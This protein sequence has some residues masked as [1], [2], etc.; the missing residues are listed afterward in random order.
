MARK[1]KKAIQAKVTWKRQ[2]NTRDSKVN[3]ETGKYGHKAADCWYKQP[4]KLQGKGK[5]TG[6]SKSKVTEISVSDGSKQVDETWTSNTSTPQPKISQVNTIG[7]ANEGLWIFSLEDS[8]KRRYTVNWEDQSDCK[9][10]RTRVD[11]RF[12]MFWTCLPTPWFAPQFPMVS[13]TIVEAVA[14]NNVGL[15]HFGQK[16]VYGHVMTNSGRRISIQIKFDV[17]SVRNPLLS[18]FALKRRGVTIIFN[19]DDNRF[20]SRNETVIFDNSRLSFLLTHHSGE[21]NP[22]SDSDGDG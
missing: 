20:I 5:D 10:Q 15:Q 14:A 16:V 22:A 12:W 19:H 9:T 18:T 6:K 7:C 13:S 1:E 2:Q 8:K 17:M 4:P 11:D 3:V 21:W